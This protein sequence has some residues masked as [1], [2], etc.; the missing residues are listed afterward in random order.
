M[1]LRRKAPM[2]FPFSAFFGCMALLIP[3]LASATEFDLGDFPFE[4]I[5]ATNVDATL[6]TSTIG[7]FTT[8]AEIEDFFNSTIYSVNL[9]DGATIVFTLDNSNSIWNLEFAALGGGTGG[10]TAT[11][12][13]TEWEIVLDFSTPQ[14]I[15]SAR[16]FLRN[17]DPFSVLQYAQEN[18][19]SDINFVDV[20]I[21]PPEGWA[22][23]TY[24]A[25]FVF[26]A[27]SI[28]EQ[29]VLVDI[30]PGSDPNAV[31]P[32]AR[33]FLPVAVLTDDDFDALWID[34]NTVAFGPSGAAPA[35]E[36]KAEDVD[37]DGDSDLILHFKTAET[38]IACGDTETI[39]TGE[40]FDG[41]AISGTD[42]IKTVPCR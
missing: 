3:A 4:F 13:A 26:P 21:L 12:T 2:I 34:Y 18:N 40:T 1:I 14:E 36:A 19:I 11:L 22:E 6:E 7:V 5:E 15:S 29:V 9:M 20:Y 30:K 10:A 23:V 39:L 41:Q 42:A 33:G 38:G 35:R 16:L 27:T 25:A 24:D 28:P 37:G 31:N 8:E 17:T 32:Y